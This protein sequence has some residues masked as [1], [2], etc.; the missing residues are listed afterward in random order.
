MTPAV[1]CPSFPE[2]DP[3]HLG[4]FHHARTAYWSALPAHWALSERIFDGCARNAH[5]NALVAWIRLHQ[6]FS[7]GSKGLHDHAPLHPVLLFLL[8]QFLPSSAS[9]RVVLYI[10]PSY[11]SP[12]PQSEETNG[13]EQQHL[14]GKAY[15]NLALDK[16]IE[17]SLCQKGKRSY[18]A[19]CQRQGTSERHARQ[20]EVDLAPWCED[21]WRPPQGGGGF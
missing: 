11:P 2:A 19:W 7:G 21:F 15:S 18:C 4:A 14:A 13:K 12:D 9:C 16:C 10:I 6:Q 17:T 1:G 20:K 8:L 5:Y 3:L